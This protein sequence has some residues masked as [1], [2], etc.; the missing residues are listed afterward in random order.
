[1]ID[2]SENQKLG[3]TAKAVIVV[4]II[5]AI[6]IPIA[7]GTVLVNGSLPLPVKTTAA[8]S[9]TSTGSASVNTVILPQG[10]SAG[11]NFAPSTLTVA[12]G[13][14][15][16]FADQDTGAPHNVWFTSVPTGATNPNTAA[17]QSSYYTMTAGDSVSFTLTTPGVYHYECQFHTGWMQATITVTG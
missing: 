15:I 11:L 13:T 7:L 6:V 17:G 5:I 10:A 2:M 1:V 4:L 12:S 16:T 9:T 3:G 14:T 8:V